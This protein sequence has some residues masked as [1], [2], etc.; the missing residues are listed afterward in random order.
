MPSYVGFLRAV[1]V[2]HRQIPMARVRSALKTAG[3]ADVETHIQTGNVHVTSTLRTPAKVA[4]VMRQALAAEFGFDVPTVVRTPDQLTELV[5]AVDALPHP[6]PAGRTYAAF[7]AA[8]LGPEATAT[9]DDWDS[10][11][12]WARVLGPHVVLRLGIPAHRA[13][14][15]NTRIERFGVTATTRDLTVVRAVAE[16]WGR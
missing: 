6:F 9:L 5:T 13:R 15:T 16:R 10:P 14:L 1:N 12:E 4:A 7:L 11:G 2:G 8:P 3:L